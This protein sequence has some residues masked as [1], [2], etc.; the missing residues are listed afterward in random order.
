MISLSNLFQPMIKATTTF[1]QSGIR[2]AMLSVLFFAA[3]STSAQTVSWSDS[4][5][6]GQTP[7]L[8]QCQKWTGFLD[9]LGGK[10]FAS[11][12]I[13]G[14]RDMTG[15][16]IT[17]P[18]AVNELAKLL[19]SRTPGTVTSGNH[20]WT[21]TSCYAGNCGSLSTALSVDGNTQSCACED[22]YTIRPH[23]TNGDWGGLNVS[24]SCGAPSQ[25]MSLEFS[26][27]VYI[28]SNGS[29][30][31]CKGGSV[32]L[33]ANSDICT[34]PLTYLWSNGAT[35][36]SITISQAGSYSVTV[37]DGN[38]CSGISA[39]VLV[40]LSDVDVNAGADVIFCDVPVQLTALGTSAGGSGITVNEFCIYNAPG[41]WAGA[42]DC[43]FTTDVCGEGFVY[44]N[45][46]SYSTTTSLSNPV[47]LRYHIY[48]SSNIAPTTFRF[49]VN[50]QVVGSYLETDDAGN[51]ET[52]GGQRFPRSFTF[53]EAAFKQ[54]WIEGGENNIAVDIETPDR[55]VMLAGITAEVVSS[56]EKYLWSPAAGLD[57]ASIRNPL[58]NP[59]ATTLYTV[60][61]T[62]ANGCT[63]TDEVSVQVQCGSAPIARCKELIVDLTSGCEVAID[64]ATFDAGSTGV[65]PLTFSIS[66]AGPFTVGVTNVEFTVKDSNGG[67]S[68]CSGSVKVIDKI[69]PVI[70][71]PIDIVA[72]SGA[73]GCFALLPLV[74]PVAL[75]NCP[76]ANITHDQ[77][78][79]TLPD[80]TLA[81]KF[82]VGE[83]IVTWTATDKSGNAT[84]ATQKISVSNGAP[85]I[86]SVIASSPAV[87]INSPVTLTIGY[88]DTNAST[89][90]I[91]WGDLS[92]AQLV[93]NPAEIFEVSHS[94][95]APGFYA[96]TVMVTDHCGAS[97]TYVYESINVFDRGG[98]V[99]G[100]GWFE[101]KPGYQVRNER[102]AGKAQFRFEA[103]YSSASTVPTGAISF[104]FRTGGLDFRSSNLELLMIE[105]DKAT[106]TGSGKVNG[107][108]DY[109][110]LI[111]AVDVQATTTSTLTTTS[112]TA[113]QKGNDKKV[114]AA[115]RV[116]VQISDPAGTVIYDTQLGA[117]DDAIASN[118]LAG[119]SISVQTTST[120]VQELENA[121][122]S[123]FS[124]E[125]TSV[126]PNPFIDHLSVQF[127]SS[128][129]EQVLVQLSDLSGKTIASRSF[130]VS[131]D[132]YYNIDVPENANEGIYL[133]TIRQGKRVEYLKLVKQ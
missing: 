85:V 25:T 80:G 108:R 127:N 90:S 89:A 30:T 67:S 38:G 93:S 52:V 51:C 14:S 130:P 131:D 39:S 116:R 123:G 11:V 118:D 70:N 24:S 61:Y 129:L 92:S 69:L 2:I 48:Y 10:S 87:G 128:S 113:T 96:V 34:A 94:Y 84:T 12:T 115:D 55:G 7:S 98:S 71:T 20:T 54:Y 77:A 22:K 75:D 31:F 72:Q 58:A 95:S 114:K 46:S 26:S 43:T 35:T 15:F 53:N 3:W 74:A 9:Q 45:S 120:F 103:K 32:E 119:G 49:K 65:G 122:A 17:D 117:P 44:A 88:F 50:S 42:D 112:S 5:E 62:D 106:L 18:V 68:I 126:Y 83:T 36:R 60:T 110:I 47:E 121:I 78:V 111:S 86:T 1:R 81:V 97:D 4:F 57:N 41:A 82:P 64:A 37:S 21:V 73:D 56:K 27:G 76:I 109:S 13:K 101:S 107:V 79:E 125:S 23:S 66:P 59:I 33:T 100:E 29:T 133:L 28:S 105:G 102:A 132:G 63:A 6:Q 8:E 99:I 40:S 16:T 91:S 104:K 124:E 19:Y